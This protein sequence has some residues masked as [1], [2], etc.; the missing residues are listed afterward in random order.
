MF[1]PQNFQQ[2]TRN[3]LNTT[4]AILHHNTWSYSEFLKLHRDTIV[5]SPPF[6][7]EWNGLDGAWS[8]RFLREVK[9]LN[10]LNLK[11]LEKKVI[12][13]LF[14]PRALLVSSHSD[15]EYQFAFWAQVMVS[16]APCQFAF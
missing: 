7:D 16:G 14:C 8:K 10:P 15:Q 6:A 9:V 11:V 13:T 3:P 5:S 12:F 1:P 2:G 4:P